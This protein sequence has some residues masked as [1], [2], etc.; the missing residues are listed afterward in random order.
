[1]ETR[2]ISGKDYE[3]FSKSIF[4]AK[5]QQSDLSLLT[6]WMQ[7][8]QFKSNSV[9]LAQ[10]K[11][12]PC[13]FFAVLQSHIVLHLKEISLNNPPE[14]L[15]IT[16]I[17]DIFKRLSTYINLKYPESDSSNKVNF[18][19]CD[20]LDTELQ[21]CRF[22]VTDSID[23]ANSYLAETD[24]LNSPA[25]CL[26][27][28]M[29]FIFASFGLTKF[30]NV[31]SEPYIAD[32]QMTSMSLV[33]LL[34]NG[35]TDD[36]NLSETENSEYK[37]LAQSEIG[38]KVCLSFDKRVIGTWLNKDASIFV[39][40]AFNHFFAAAEES[41]NEVLKYDSLEEGGTPTKIAKESLNW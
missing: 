12:G 22:K 13:G 1:M 10:Q 34:L 18:V 15:L 24:Y 40:L 36:S 2:E 33:W 17:L 7:P 31:N 23:L 32:D 20:G 19:F 37:G 29:S 16:I 8:L 6:N 28:T 3:T 35:S 26:F 21:T 25:A 14:K 5:S 4:V 30:V 38:I 27:L 41:E 39:C 9:I 11:I